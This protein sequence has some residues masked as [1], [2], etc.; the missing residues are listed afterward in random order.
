M[1]NILGIDLATKNCGLCFWDLGSGRHGFSTI[2]LKDLEP[3]TVIKFTQVFCKIV[4][5]MNIAV[6]FNLA[7]ECYLPGKRNHTAIKYFMAG[8]IQEAALSCLFVTPKELREFYGMTAKQPKELLHKLFVPEE[9]ALC[10]EHQKDA[11]LL[12][13]MLQEMNN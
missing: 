4:E 10:D 8:A 12:A 5:G 6:D 13:N 7:T 2:G 9:L 1:N 3:Q 11:W